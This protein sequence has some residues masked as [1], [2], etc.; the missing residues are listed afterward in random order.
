MN[1]II[2]LPKLIEFLVKVSSKDRALCEKFISAFSSEVGEAL[3]ASG[4]V[5]L[6]GFGQ[7]K[8]LTHDGVRRIV[9]VPDKDLADAVNA[10]FAC[11]EP[12]ELAPG[13][14]EDV[15]ASVD[16]ISEA[17]SANII[18]DQSDVA[19][20]DKISD[21]S[22]DPIDPPAELSVNPVKE[23]MPA[24]A[25][26][27][28]ASTEGNQ[29]PDS[30]A[31]EVVDT[32]EIDFG[33]EI[34]AITMDDGLPENVREETRGYR[35]YGMT[36]DSDTTEDSESS[37]VPESTE[38]PESPE[39]LNPSE[40]SEE[41]HRDD[42]VDAPS[43]DEM[44]AQPWAA[45]RTEEDI[46][47]HSGMDLL[48]PEARKRRQEQQDKKKSGKMRFADFPWF[49]VAI[50]YIAGMAIGFG[51]GFF[52]HDYIKGLSWDNENTIDL[53]A[54]QPMD[55]SDD[56]IDLTGT[57]DEDLY[58]KVDEPLSQPTDSDSTART[59]TISTVAAKEDSISAPKLGGEHVYDI[60]T[61]N[62]NLNSLAQKHYGNRVYWVYIFLD[63][64]D[65]IK[66]PNSVIVG[67]KLRIPPKAQYDVSDKDE[68]ANIKAALRKQSE[69]YTQF[70]MQ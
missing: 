44:P 12:V 28:S 2:S 24:E 39:S 53:S 65:K 7:F 64:Q 38:D 10:P 27:A 51:L 45:A 16:D 56:V 48:T 41:I 9:F 25:Q 23:E 49:W 13:V 14:D 42:E 61:Q 54:A 59:D 15:L 35:S 55:S 6:R 68:E 1:S 62:N 36:E 33:I 11:F 50:A 31:E 43:Y 29:D 69:I 21:D 40:S 5:K 17:D 58:S 57:D 66:N 63:N 60:I 20:T 26:G 70:G 30:P 34:P 4:S 8:V 37:E 22:E 32:V 18:M 3:G 52:G 67:T 46:P 19:L 47:L